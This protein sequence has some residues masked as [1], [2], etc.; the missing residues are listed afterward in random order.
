MRAVDPISEETV[1]LFHP[2]R[3]NWHEH[4]AWSP[5]C[6]ILKGLTATGR[7]TIAALDLNRQ[8]VINL[9]RIVIRDGLHPPAHRVTGK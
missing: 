2:R 1:P 9:R 8:R 3:D 7:A 6:L 5:D 4:F